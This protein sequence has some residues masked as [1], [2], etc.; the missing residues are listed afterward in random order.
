MPVRAKICGLSTPEAVDAAIAGG[1]SHIGLNF[2]PQSPRY[3]GIEQA[4]AL[5]ARA[6]GRI[7]IVGLFVDP[8]PEQIDAVRAQVRLDALQLHGDES[9]QLAAQLRTRNALPIWKAIG[10]RAAAD[11][12]AASRYRDAADLI[13]YDAKPPEDAGLTGGTG[14]RFD[15]TLLRGVHHPL[16]WG[17]AGGLDASN[18][19]EAVRTTGA[20]LVDAS[21]GV[22]RARGV[23][24]VDKIAAFLKAAHQL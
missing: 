14:T 12:S 18:L 10:V 11:L 22:E 4:A 15:W 6:A 2:Y 24:D 16:P 9:P 19:A 17:L 1:A 13:L 8:E 5:A 7:A 23:K 21:S 20:T 3:V